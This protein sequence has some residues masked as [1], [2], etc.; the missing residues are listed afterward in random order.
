MDWCIIL[1]VKWN[2]TVTNVT[3]LLVLLIV[4]VMQIR[5]GRAS[6][7]LATVSYRLNIILTLQR[8]TENSLSRTGLELVSSGQGRR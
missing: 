6:N 1:R 7:R 4:T 2:F 3:N 5:R 8:R